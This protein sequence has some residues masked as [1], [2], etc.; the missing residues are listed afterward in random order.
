MWVVVLFISQSTEHKDKH[1]DSTVKESIKRKRNDISTKK[2]SNTI[3]KY[4][5]QLS[6]SQPSPKKQKTINNQVD[7]IEQVTTN[8]TSKKENSKSKK[9][10][11]HN[12]DDSCIPD[13]LKL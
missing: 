3:D 9:Q 12:N 7:Q 8:G 1:H 11:N 6:I 13:Y 10:I 4:L 5:S 2:S